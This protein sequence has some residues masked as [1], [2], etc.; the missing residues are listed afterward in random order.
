MAIGMALAGG[1]AGFL[2]VG[3]F[4]SLFDNPRPAT[5]FFIVLF[6]GLQ[7]STPPRMARH[8]DQS[9][10]PRAIDAAASERGPALVRS[11]K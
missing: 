11:V 2:L 6:W 1:L 9:R 10:S 4:G 7:R 3:S 5:L 8:T